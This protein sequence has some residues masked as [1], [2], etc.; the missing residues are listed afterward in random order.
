MTAEPAGAREPGTAEPA[1]Y[2]GPEQRLAAEFRTRPSPRRATPS[3]EEIEQAW[4]VYEA[5]VPS[6]FSRQCLA[7][8]CGEWPCRSYREAV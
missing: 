2:A 6:M 1:G 7:P 5:H 8:G 4:R 3:A